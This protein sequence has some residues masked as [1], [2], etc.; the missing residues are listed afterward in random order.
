MRGFSLA[1][2]IINPTCCILQNL[3]TITS[4]NLIMNKFIAGTLLLLSLNGLVL[5][6][7]CDWVGIEVGGRHD[8][9]GITPLFVVQIVGE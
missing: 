3:I 7:E 4:N 2:F 6:S 1:R 8:L 9:K 5:A